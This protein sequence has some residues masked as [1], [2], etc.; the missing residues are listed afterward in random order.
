MLIKHK[1]FSLVWLVFL[2]FAGQAAATD[3]NVI[4]LFPGK[5]VVVINGNKPRILSTGEISPEGVKLISADSDSADFEIDGKRQVL[6][7]GNRISSNFAPADNSSVTLT[8]D[9]SGHFITEGSINGATV[10]FIIDTG[11]TM[12]SLNS[13]EARRIGLNYLKGQRGVV[14]T[15]NGPVPVY[16]VT[17]DNVKIGDISLNNVDA[18]VQEGEH[19]PMALM[20]MSFLN[21]VDMKREGSEMTLT[22]RY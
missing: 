3:I 11:A 5:A 22:K 8:A 1:N 6:G 20:G 16:K 10:K 17:L 4:G 12:I 15:A 9:S 19:L 13:S 14:S 21:R 2:L 7:L 18:L